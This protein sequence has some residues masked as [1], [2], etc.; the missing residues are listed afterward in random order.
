MPALAKSSVGSSSGTTGED[1]TNV[2]PCF[3]QKKSMNC[4]RTSLALGMKNPHKSKPY[5]RLWGFICRLR[6]AEHLVQRHAALAGHTGTIIVLRRKHGRLPFD[7]SQFAAHLAPRRL[8]RVRFSMKLGSLH[9]IPTNTKR[10]RL[11]EHDFFDCR[12][13]V[14]WRDC[15]QD[16][17]G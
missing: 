2:W 13:G 7:P 10:L 14:F 4:W 5:G 1:G 15:A 17:A 9:G 8:N 16:P 11:A 3:L 6:H 12:D